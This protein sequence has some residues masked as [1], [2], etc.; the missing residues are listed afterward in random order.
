MNRILFAI[1]TL[2]TSITYSI[3][4]HIDSAP[5]G[6]I[7]DIIEVNGK[8][9]IGLEGNGI[10][11]STDGTLSWQQINNGIS[12]DALRVESLMMT[13]SSLYIATVD[14]IYKST[15]DGSSWVKKSNGLIIGGG[16]NNYFAIS[17]YEHLGTLFAGTYSGIY[18]STDLGEN[19]QQTNIFGSEIWVDKFTFFN[20][21]LYAGRDVINNPSLF[22][23][24]NGGF[25]WFVVDIWNNFPVEVFCFFGETNNLFVGT[26]LGVWLSTNDGLSWTSRNVGLS[27]D[28]YSTSI[29]KVGGTMFTSL[30]F[31]G[32]GIYRSSND[33]LNWQGINGGLPFLN[34]ISKLINYD[35]L[36]I[37]STSNGLYQRNLSEILVGIENKNQ[38]AYK[39][40]LYQNYPN[41]FNP[42]ST[43]KFDMPKSS[44]VK[45]VI[46]NTIG[47]EVFT[48]LNS[49]FEP[50]S[51]SV[52]W[53]ASNNPSGVYFYRIT[54]SKFT[55]VKKMILLK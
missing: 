14:G 46:Y 44:D 12:G 13:G 18:R 40:K 35:S 17:M 54:T 4:A 22:K 51:Y 21:A 15:N 24:T 27:P 3:W 30:E 33:G 7:N 42:S 2:Y 29:I 37:A 47:Q 28:P 20:N 23:S 52:Q 1:L 41:P 19:W 38:T 32:S 55:D 25:N 11:K 9:F 34:A 49:H 36:L 50:G 16:S 53:N 5:S 6:Y 43:I 10:Y 31:G 48:L 8:F 26:A 45:I 39:F